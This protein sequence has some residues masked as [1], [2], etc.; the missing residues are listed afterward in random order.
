M[1]L[2]IR[3]IRLTDE[4]IKRGNLKIDR[5]FLLTEGY[6]DHAFMECKHM[7]IQ[8]CPFCGTKLHSFYKSEEYVQEILDIPKRKE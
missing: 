5:N 3:L 8:Y 4:F 7:V 6:S 1:G 2:N